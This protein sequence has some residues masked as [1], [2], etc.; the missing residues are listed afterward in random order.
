MNIYTAAQLKEWDRYSMQHEPIASIDLME[1]A[2]GQCNNWLLKNH[3]ACTAYCIVCGNGNN[4]G[5]GLALARMLLKENLNVRVYVL[6]AAATSTADFETNL[7]RLAETGHAAVHQIKDEKDFPVWQQGETI[8]EAIFGISLSRPPGGIAAALIRH[9]N[10]SHCTVISIDIPAGMYADSSSAGNTIIKATHTLTFQGLKPAFLLAANSLYTGA[11]HVLDIGLLKGFS[12]TS[13]YKLI[14]TI[15]AKEIFR[16][17]QQFAHKG[18]FGHALLLAGSYGKIGAAVLCAAACL[19]SGAGLLTGFLPGC[20][21]S[22]M[23]TALPEAMVISSEEE[24]ILAGQLPDTGTGMYKAIGIGP[25][26][27]QAAGTA[28]LLENVLTASTSPIVLDADALNIIAANIQLAEKIPAGAVLTPHP[29]EFDRLFGASANEF[30]RISK[31]LTEAARYNLFIVLKGHHSFVATPGGYGYFN[32][33]G[34]AGMATAGS[35]DVLTGIITGLLAQGYPPEQ[36]A[37]LGVYLHGLAGDIAAARLS[38]E[39]MI[40]GDICSSIGAAYLH[41]SG[42]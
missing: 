19:R 25:G 35:G 32:T 2:A 11:V 1:R 17:R 12:M 39:A 22:I 23:Q 10:N 9:I 5:D 36:A 18:N 41:V 20:G 14:D 38:Q 13:P 3:G 31:A 30:E 28:A 37:V 24:K 27:G 21:I 26:I 8:V 42:S 15:L 6:H 40:A 34:N 33:T 16:P 4:G 29:K 7:A